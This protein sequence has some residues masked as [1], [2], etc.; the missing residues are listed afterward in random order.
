MSE[1]SGIATLQ[2]EAKFDVEIEKAPKELFHLTRTKSLDKI[3]KSGLTPKASTKFF[4]Y[5][6]RIYFSTDLEPL[7]DLALQKNIIEN[8]NEFVFLRI[9][10]AKLNYGI[11]FFKD[12]NFI[13]GVYTL[14]NVS[15]SAIEPYAKL[16]I[17]EDGSYKIEEFKTKSTPPRKI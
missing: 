12:P 13:N 11:R 17:A 8:D 9:N 6:D 15:K 4:N 16:H 3:L 7:V 5:K 14:E 10:G 2:Y 1:T